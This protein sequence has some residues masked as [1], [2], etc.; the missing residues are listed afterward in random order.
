MIVAHNF[1]AKLSSLCVMIFLVMLLVLHFIK[2]DVDP[3]RRMI[4]EYEIGR[5]GWLMQ[6]AFIYIAISC[7]SLGIAIWLI[8]NRI[9]A[10][11]GS[12][13]FVIAAAGMIIAAANVTDPIDA[14]QTTSHG[15]LHAIGF[16]IGI[17]SLIIAC[18]IISIALRSTPLLWLTVIQ[19]FSIMALVAGMALDI[20]KL[21]GGPNRLYIV[22][23]CVWIIRMNTGILSLRKRNE[24]AN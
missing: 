3:I 9:S 13:M 17:P 18:A 5:F 16:L 12:V 21:I 20:E 6:L 10:K 11:I 15:D 14:I 24:V 4:S 7:V 23:C 19:V 8:T 1:F 2:S 22:A